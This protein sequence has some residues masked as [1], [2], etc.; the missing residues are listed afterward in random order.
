MKRKCAAWFVIVFITAVLLGILGKEPE[1]R[2]CATV[3]GV[4]YSYC[5]KNGGICDLRIDRVDISSGRIPS[6]RHGDTIDYT[7]KVPGVFQIGQEFFAVA[8]IGDG[9]FKDNVVTGGAID[10]APGKVTTENAISAT[11]SVVTGGGV[12]KAGCYMIS[13][14]FTDTFLQEI[15]DYAFSGDKEQGGNY[16]GVE[17]VDRICGLTN[18]KTV[19]DYAFY[20]CVS[21]SSVSLPMCESVGKG[22]FEETTSLQVGS[23]EEIMQ[24]GDYAFR[25]SG[26]KKFQGNRLNYMGKAV[27]K[28]CASLESFQADCLEEIREDTFSGC[29][30]LESVKAD[31]VV[32]LG[33]KSFR[34]CAGL[35]DLSME[36]LERLDSCAFWGCKQIESIEGNNVTAVG[37]DAFNS[38]TSLVT[39]YLPKVETIGKYGFFRCTSLSNFHAD[40]LKQIGTGS[41]QECSQLEQFQAKS[42]VDV[43]DYAFYQSGEN[44]VAKKIFRLGKLRIVGEGAFKNC[45]YITYIGTEYLEKIGRSAFSGS[46]LKKCYLY[47]DNVSAD[48]FEGAT[49][50]TL[51]A[52]NPNTDFVSRDNGTD[53]TIKDVEKAL[54][55]VSVCGYKRCSIGDLLKDSGNFMDFEAYR[56][57]TGD[58][59]YIPKNADSFKVIFSYPEAP[60]GASYITDKTQDEH[61]LQRRGYAYIPFE[62][63]ELAE[64]PLHMRTIPE[65][66]E[67]GES[68]YH[69]SGYFYGELQIVDNKGAFSSVDPTVLSVKKDNVVTAVFTADSYSITYKDSWFKDDVERKETY[70]YGEEMLLPGEGDVSRTG[71]SFDGW[72]LADSTE[73]CEK[74][75]KGTE[76][77]LVFIGQWSP[78]EYVVTYDGNGSSTDEKKVISDERIFGET[79]KLRECPFEKVGYIFEG[80]I[81]EKENVITAIEKDTANDVVLY[82]SW[83]PKKYSISYDCGS[84][85]ELG[86]DIPEFYTIESNTFSLPI[87]KRTGYVFNGWRRDKDETKIDKVKKGST[88]DLKLTASWIKEKYGITYHWNGGSAEDYLE[89]YEYG[90]GGVLPITKKEHYVFEGW[91]QE[92]D[93]SGNA[94][95]EISAFDLGNKEFY[96]KWSPVS[97]TITFDPDGG[98]CNIEAMSYTVETDEDITVVPERTGYVF[99]G[100]YIDG[101][102]IDH[103]APGMSGD[104]TVSASWK[105]KRTQITYMTDGGDIKDTDYAQEHV[106]GS[107]E[108]LPVDVKKKGYIFKGWYQEKDFSGDEFF[109]ISKTDDDC[110]FYAKWEPEVYTYRYH[111]TDSAGEACLIEKK[112][113]YGDIIPYPDVTI[114]DC[115]LDKWVDKKSDKALEKNSYVVV[116]G[117]RDFVAVV[118]SVHIY[119]IFDARGGDC[120]ESQKEVY[121]GEKAGELPTPKKNGFEFTGWVTANGTRYSSET[122]IKLKPGSGVIL[123]ATYKQ[124]DSEKGDIINDVEQT[125]PSEEEGDDTVCIDGSEPIL[126]TETKVWYRSP[127]TG[128]YYELLEKEEKRIYSGLYNYYKNGQH[129]GEIFSCISHARI[130]VPEIQNAAQAFMFDHKEISWI[131]GIQFSIERSGDETRLQFSITSGYDYEL[132]VKSYNS[133]SS[134]EEYE[135]ILASTGVKE[136]DSSAEKV[137]KICCTVA[138][139]ITYTSD[140]GKDGR[141]SSKYRDAAYVVFVNEDHEAVCVGYAVL[142]QQICHYYGLDCVIVSGSTSTGGHA[143][144]YVKLGKKWYGVDATW[145]DSDR[146]GDYILAGTSQFNA[147]DRKYSTPILG[148]DLKEVMDFAEEDYVD[149]DHN[150]METPVPTV[151]PVS[152]PSITPLESGTPVPAPT[153]TVMI[154]YTP[155]PSGTGSMEKVETEAASGGKNINIPIDNLNKTADFIGSEFVYSVKGNEILISGLTAAGGRQKN[156]V[157]PNTLGKGYF[158][159]IKKN[160]FKSAEIKSIVLGDG[161]K[162]IGKKAFYGCKKLKRV[163]VRSCVLSKV[164]GKIFCRRVIVRA[165][166]KKKNEYKKLF[167]GQKAKIK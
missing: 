25:H 146:S 95:I 167:L 107:E 78:K 127:A 29:T 64:K 44:S 124:Y 69:F 162:E 114:K 22:A 130:D 159:K 17:K 122:I 153:S 121:A 82:A 45:N 43:G 26:V 55:G 42:L 160:A 118:R 149:E 161:V 31:G 103:I 100:W 111:Y 4:D 71:Y 132:V 9:F 90:T 66:D 7:I 73:Y 142:F 157:I 134:S 145:Y 63:A 5:V 28:D 54:Y 23:L 87:P 108:Q 48:A 46:G 133:I 53:L 86:E 67:A 150:L 20:R 80:W 109:K 93:F 49:Q 34:G 50:L 8:S 70:V 59:A 60:Y 148:K 3:N 165:P 76:G 12:G 147:Y 37:E 88:G 89:T 123:Y 137:R 83:V 72:M 79:Y 33:S 35:K 110:T 155:V 81:D 85:G 135:R 36:E 1:K 151:T 126:D 97:Y 144:N 129:M 75:P 18:V 152:P 158:V 115:T 143:W 47:A 113:A 140:V 104:V 39:V 74:I 14:D 99:D 116:T 92:K 24:L 51:F 101:S 40:Q 94:C 91:Y 58:G 154:L 19:G 96:A 21:I 119:L 166:K 138:D 77:N 57:I 32:K 52:M 131:G 98:S 41:F 30:S 6:N 141:Y 11:A 106:Y 65:L 156:L 125:N 105:L 117:D 62:Y 15:P 61:V 120:A 139:Y 13:L 112:V 56:N 163:A 16:T 10:Y 164:K 2:L 136:E 102:K 38:C 128:M 68:H 27:F 84:E